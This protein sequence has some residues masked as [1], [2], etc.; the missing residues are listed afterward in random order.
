MK[1][2]PL[3]DSNRVVMRLPAAVDDWPPPCFLV[4]AIRALRSDPEERVLILMDEASQRSASDPSQHLARHLHTF[5]NSTTSVL[6]PQD[7]DG[8]TLNGYMTNATR[9]IWA[10]LSLRL[11]APRKRPYESVW[12]WCQGDA[13]ACDGAVLTRSVAD[14]EVQGKLRAERNGGKQ[15]HA[16]PSS[17]AHSC[18]RFVSARSRWTQMLWVDMP[19]GAA[20]EQAR[21]RGEWMLDDACVAYRPNLVPEGRSRP[22]AERFALL[23]QA[24]SASRQL[25]WPLPWPDIYA[26]YA[27]GYTRLDS[28]FN[29]GF[30]M[31]AWTTSR[32]GKREALQPDQCVWHN[33]TSAFLT[34][35]TMDNLYHAFIHAV[36]TLEH[37]ER[38]PPHMHGSGVHILPQYMFYWPTGASASRQPPYVGWQILARSLGVKPDEWPAVDARARALTASNSCNCYR[39]IH[40]GHGSFMPP[41]HSPIDQTVQRVASFRAS[42]AASL[43]HPIRPQRRIL[44]QLRRNGN[45]QIVNEVEFRAGVEADPL[46]GK[47]VRFAVMEELPVMD[48]YALLQSS[49]ALAGVHGMGLAWTML[50]PSDAR[51]SSSCLEIL[52][53]WPSFQRNDYYMLSK[54]NNVYYIRIQQRSSPE[55]I[56]KGCHYRVCGNVTGNLTEVVP[57]LRYMAQRWSAPV[58]Y[59]DRRPRPVRCHSPKGAIE[60]SEVCPAYT[61]S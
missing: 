35:L 21:P 15:R 16:L 42:L 8:Q 4:A 44:F 5:R 11:P 6:L 60:S 53:T 1:G 29:P 20:I 43:G 50:L 47:L 58:L 12:T 24:N 25:L 51:G 46:V 13:A 18:A 52:G 41:P 22:L 17:S 34:Q 33:D 59:E 26:E 7:D 10:D 61:W 48:Q 9:V 37:Y 56:C 2:P 40:G 39:R 45:R 32:M 28:D 36:P 3:A 19:H 30:L 14:F 31:A 49:R 55:C 23:V 38:M 54:A 27:P 57:A